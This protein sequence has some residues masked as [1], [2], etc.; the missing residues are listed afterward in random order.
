MNVE[1]DIPFVL[2]SPYGDLPFNDYG[3][4]EPVSGVTWK[5]DP[6]KC[7]TLAPIRATND[8]RSQRDGSVLHREFTEG[9]EI[10]LSGWAMLDDDTPACGADLRNFYQELQRA[11]HALLGND[12]V[13]DGDNARLTWT[14]AGYG[15]T[16]LMLNIRLLEE[17]AVQIDEAIA[18]VSVAF[19]GPLPYAVDGT[20]Q[21]L[22]ITEGTGSNPGVA[23][24]AGNTPE[25]PNIK[26]YGP[27]AGRFELS[28]AEAGKTFVYDTSLPGAHVILTG[29]YAFINMFEE[30]IYLDGSGQNLKAGVD[31][32]NS[33]FYALEPGNNTLTLEPGT[34]SGTVADVIWNNAWF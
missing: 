32:E 12:V 28:N 34:D 30:S 26:V 3:S 24:N 25:Y 33:D 14:P 21:T 5:L 13:L 9:Y 17:V 18:E 10:R 2:T 22:T 16:R 27:I 29:H 20:E 23:L 7:S 6:S 19:K 31:V 1:W 8:N 15:D 4:P 11:C